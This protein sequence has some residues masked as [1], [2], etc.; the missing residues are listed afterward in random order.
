MASLKEETNRLVESLL[1]ND[2]EE[3]YDGKEAPVERKDVIEELVRRKESVLPALIQLIERYEKEKEGR[4]YIEYVIEILGRIGES[5]SSE[6][7]LRI[8]LASIKADIDND[9]SSSMSIIWL[10]KL[11]KTAVP[12]IIRVVEENYDET[13]VVMSVAEA[14]E[15][16]ADGRLVPLL[17]RLLKY[18]NPTVIQSALVSLRKQDDKSVVPYIIPLT[19]YKDENPAEQRETRE[20]AQRTLESLLRDDQRM[21]R[22]T[23]SEARSRPRGR[24]TMSARGTDWASIAWAY[25]EKRNGEA[26]I[27]YV[28]DDDSTHIFLHMPRIRDNQG[29]WVDYFDF[30]ERHGIPFQKGPDFGCLAIA[31]NRILLVKEIEPTTI[32]T[33]TH[34]LVCGNGIDRDAFCGEECRG[35]FYV[36]YGNEIVAQHLSKRLNHYEKARLPSDTTVR[37]MFE[38]VLSD[39][40]RLQEAADYLVQDY[41][42]KPTKVTLRPYE[43]LAL[44]DVID[45][46]IIISSTKVE[47]WK[48]LG[49]WEAINLT[50]FEHLCEC[51]SWKFDDDPQ[52]SIEKQRA[53]TR[54][55]VERMFG[56]CVKLGLMPPPTRGSFPPE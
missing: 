26:I 25:L 16:I 22:K 19:Q 9:D 52:R 21:L 4:Y 32:G 33:S 28:D 31:K 27:G 13:F 14:M 20:F 40:P 54:L 11:G 34:C 35:L 45:N 15:E 7:I 18:P 46:T 2:R 48:Q 24:E 12:A 23:K 41:G 6:L 39:P 1:V 8:L 50:L 29:R 38:A 37:A 47:K 53:E 42:I 51:Q 56:R 30:L 55:F 36:M 10:R 3:V 17:L 5:Q 49:L 44:Y 43:L